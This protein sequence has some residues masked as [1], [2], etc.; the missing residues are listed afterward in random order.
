MS[1]PV[2]Y[3]AAAYELLEALSKGLVLG[4][5]VIVRVVRVVHAQQ[6]R[7]Q[8]GPHLRLETLPGR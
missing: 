5:P 4:V 6:Q 8:L 2:P 3:L 7:P 1:W